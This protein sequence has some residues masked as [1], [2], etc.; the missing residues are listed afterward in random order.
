VLGTRFYLTFEAAAYRR[1]RAIGLI[2]PVRPVWLIDNLPAVAICI[3]E[4][5]R[6]AAAADPAAVADRVDRVAERIVLETWE[7]PARA[8]DPV[9][10]KIAARLAADYAAPEKI[11]ELAR[12]HGLSATDFRRRWAAALPDTTPARHR[13]AARLREV[14]RLLVET[15]LGLRE[16]AAR[17]G[18]ADEFHL[19]RRFRADTGEPPSAYRRRYGHPY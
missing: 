13:Q 1:F 4:L 15:R 14:C 6:L 18:F 2:D 12:E 3:D 9:I 7:P 16:I 17:A 11:E 19:S 5:A 10:E 8:A